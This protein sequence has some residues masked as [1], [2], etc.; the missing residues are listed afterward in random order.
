MKLWCHS[1]LG[2]KSQYACLKKQNSGITYGSYLLFVS[3]FMILNFKMGRISVNLPI[4]IIKNI[5]WRREMLLCRIHI[6]LTCF[7]TSG[8]LDCI[9][10]Y[11]PLL[12]LFFPSFI[13][14]EHKNITLICWKHLQLANTPQQCL[15]HSSTFI[16]NIKQK[17]FHGLWTYFGC[18]IKWP[19]IRVTNS[20]KWF[21]FS[22]N[23][24]ISV[25]NLLHYRF[26][27]CP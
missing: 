2:I 19:R 9:V 14:Q 20:I 10:I 17:L 13:S 25:H 23:E 8:A 3:R 22:F 21:I 7:A 26:Q 6:F 15:G 12:I 24:N 27:V 1:K 16:V 11:C 18:L 5:K 4:I